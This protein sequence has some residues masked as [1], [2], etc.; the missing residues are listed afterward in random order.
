MTIL[1]IIFFIA[2]ISML[3]IIMFRA[4]EIKT[5]RVEISTSEKGILPKIYFRHVEKIML[6]LA[7]HIIQWVVLMVVKYWFILYTKTKKMTKE[8][9]PKIHEFFSKRP[10]TFAPRKNSFVYKAI[11]ESKIKI[12][13]IKEKIKREHEK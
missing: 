9:L 6:Y 12:K 2:I 8:K 13:N 11:L 3:G 7:K 5:N 1:I 4:W 10:E